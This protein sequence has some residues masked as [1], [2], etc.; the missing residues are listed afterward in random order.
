MHNLSA[1]GKILPLRGRNSPAK[2]P[3]SFYETGRFYHSA[4]RKTGIQHRVSQRRFS[5][6]F[7]ITY[8]F[9]YFQFFQNFLNDFIKKEHNKNSMMI[10]V[11]LKNQFIN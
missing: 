11:Y 6:V 4:C 5:A 1:L 9:G 7:I 10:G 2:P 3:Y 8:I